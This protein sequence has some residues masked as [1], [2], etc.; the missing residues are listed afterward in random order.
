MM[1]ET[2]L[3]EEHAKSC[4]ANCAWKLTSHCHTTSHLCSCSHCPTVSQQQQFN[5]V[6]FFVKSQFFFTFQIEL[7]HQSIFHPTDYR[8]FKILIIINTKETNEPRIDDAR[9]D[10]S[11]ERI[12]TLRSWRRQHATQRIHHCHSIS[13][14]QY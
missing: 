2:S 12:E 11:R 13:Y 3:V 5:V 6:T 14:V 1:I 9:R 10:G 4:K 8:M 7:E